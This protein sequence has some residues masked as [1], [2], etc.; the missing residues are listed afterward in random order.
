MVKRKVTRKGNLLNSLLKLSIPV[1]FLLIFFDLF[2][3]FRSGF[4]NIQNISL[5][6][7]NENCLNGSN[8]EK[9]LNLAGQNIFFINKAKYENLVKSKYPCVKSVETVKNFPNK[10]T[11]IIYFRKPMVNLIPL[12]SGE[13]SDSGEISETSQ[14]GFLVDEGGRIFASSSALS[15]I[16]RLYIFDRKLQVGDKFKD[17]IL[18]NVLLTFEEIQ[19]QGFLVRSAIL[20]SNNILEIE[21]GTKIIIGLENDFPKKLA[22]LQLITAQAKIEEKELKLID[23]RFD[24]PVIKYDSKKN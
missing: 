2:L 5:Q 13:A 4:F 12:Q 24:N 18:N 1:V 11:I 21:S 7:P 17:N 23:L 19:K 15:N 3:F 14:S 20:T 16:P 22:S 9:D 6:T 10:V 8:I